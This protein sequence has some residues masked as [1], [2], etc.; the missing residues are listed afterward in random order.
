MELSQILALT[1]FVL[2]FA[3][4]IIG[5]I[6]RYIPAVIAALLT[7]VVVFLFVMKSPDTVIQVLN[8]GQIGHLNFWIPGQE[9]LETRGVNWQTIIFIGGMM[10]MVESMGEVGFFDWLCLSVAKLVHYRAIPIF[11]GFTLLSALLAMFIDSITVLLF[12][13][14]I[15]IELSRILKIDPVPLII[16]MIFTANTGGS[17][18]MSGD[19]PNIIIGT[20]LGF[21]FTDFITNTGPA[22]LLGTAAAMVF[23]YV[24]F[25][26]SLIT[27]RT[28]GAEMPKYPEPWSVVTRPFLFKLNVVIFLLVIVLLVTHATTGLS[29][30]FIGMIAAV[31]TLSAAHKSAWRIIKGIDWRT[32]V[33]FI[34]L[35]ITVSGLEETGLLKQLASFIGSISNGNV[36]LILTIIL[37]LSGFASAIVDNIPFAAAMVPVIASIA[38][39]TG[40]PLAPLAW[41]LALGTDIGGNG[42]PIGASANVVGTAIAEKE[43]YPITWKRYLK[44]AV[45]AT[46]L[47]LA[48]CWLYTIL[49]YT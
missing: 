48:V 7:L 21:T 16:A 14:A 34:G 41:S 10:A 19:P 30:A 5:K 46:I 40:I 4:I 20:S 45:P 33:F 8:L 37:W 26:K 2:L 42:T 12:M 11:I 47:V 13:T 39:T 32:L 18:T 15:A 36:F 28:A 25:R 23:F 44:Y 1:I 27:K 24:V 29:V 3:A 22:A 35:F 43:G 9:H 31:L 49:R 38:Q 17:A 6:H